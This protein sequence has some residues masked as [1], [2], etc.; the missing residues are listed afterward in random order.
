VGIGNTASGWQQRGLVKEQGRSR[1]RG[2]HEESKKKPSGQEVK[3][4]ARQEGARKGK[5]KRKQGA[6]MT[7]E[8]AG[9]GREGRDEM[10][11]LGCVCQKG[12]Q[13]VILLALRSNRPQRDQCSQSAHRRLSREKSD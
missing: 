4:K 6:K 5:G 12:H 2:G 13:D 10:F 7:Q 1:V 3:R 9:E 11:V 8:G